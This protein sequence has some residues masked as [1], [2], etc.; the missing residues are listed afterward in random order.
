MLVNMN[1]LTKSDLIFRDMD[2]LRE[3]DHASASVSVAF[4][5]NRIRQ[6]FEANAKGTELRIEALRKLRKAGIKTSAFI[7]VGYVQLFPILQ[8]IEESARLPQPFMPGI[9]LK[10][11]NPPRQFNSY[12]ERLFE[13]VMHVNSNFELYYHLLKRK[14]DRLHAMDISPAFFQLILDSLKTD[15]IIRPENSTD[16]GAITEV[17]VAA[18]E[19]L[20]ISN[21][22]EQ[23]I[24]EA[25]RAAK[26]LSVS[27]VVEINRRLI[28][29]LA[30]SPVTISDG[31]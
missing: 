8:W 18:F 17:T 25:R 7:A 19:T 4:N 12:I 2:I 10:K 31:T 11:M 9:S 16:I 29:H 21:H 14:K 6:K 5:D 27:L 24:I 13:E 28:G 26:A 15:T 22:T 30:F 23:F 1:H 3:M 20:E